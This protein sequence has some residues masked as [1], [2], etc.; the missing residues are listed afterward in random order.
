MANRPIL[1]IASHRQR[2]SLVIV[3]RRHRRII[4]T[5]LGDTGGGLKSAEASEAG[6]RRKVSPPRGDACVSG[7]AK[8][9]TAREHSHSIS[10]TPLLPREAR[11][12]H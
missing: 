11:R 6:P 4:A 12:G 2:S 5:H 1:T 3:E 7:A 10:F 9:D 8:A